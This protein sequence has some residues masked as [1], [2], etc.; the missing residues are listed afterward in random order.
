MTTTFGGQSTNPFQP[1]YTYPQ[2]QPAQPVSET[3]GT[4]YQPGSSENPYSPNYNPPSPFQPSQPAPPVSETKGTQYQPGSSEN[5]YQPNYQPNPYQPTAP[6]APSQPATPSQPSA[7]SPPNMVYVSTTPGTEGRLVPDPTGKTMADVFGAK[8]NIIDY[9]KGIL[10]GG[11]IGPSYMSDTSGLPVGGQST[12]PM[13]ATNVNVSTTPQAALGFPNQPI[14]FTYD[15]V[16][17]QTVEEKAVSKLYKPP[18]QESVLSVARGIVQGNPLTG[19]PL[20]AYGIASSISQFGG[21]KTIVNMGEGLKALPGEIGKDPLYGVGLVA[22]ALL[23]S[24]I[25]AIPTESIEPL[26]FVKSNTLVNAVSKDFSKFDYTGTRTAADMVSGFKGVSQPLRQ[27][28]N[29]VFTPSGEPVVS[30]L[31]TSIGVVKVGGK[32]APAVILSTTISTGMETVR[33][34][35]LSDVF[36][37]QRNIFGKVK[38][39][40]SFGLGLSESVPRG[41][42]SLVSETD[43]TITQVSQHET[44]GLAIS[45]EGF[46][47]VQD[48]A[49]VYATTPKLEM[50][51]GGKA[52][53]FT[54]PKPPIN[55]FSSGEGGTVP[56]G[57]FAGYPMTSNAPLMVKDTWSTL[58]GPFGKPSGT[59]TSE[60]LGNTLDNLK[61]TETNLGIDI[62]IGTLTSPRTGQTQVTGQGTSSGISMITGLGTVQ[63]TS[64]AQTQASEQLTVQL[65]TQTTAQQII[66]I[67][68]APFTPF[69]D[70]RF[71]ARSSGFKLDMVFGKKKKKTSKGMFGILPTSDLFD[72]ESTFVKYG[73]VSFPKGKKTEKAF[74]RQMEEYGVFARFPTFQQL[75]GGKFK[76]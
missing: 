18:G 75:K 24:G 14:N 56:A 68:L 55:T 76:L 52:T 19:V 15:L 74:G 49:T 42:V 46:K 58:T 16:P 1:N 33:D 64:Q 67:R 53:A 69:L 50:G 17:A 45:K 73:K 51:G 35:S 29:A 22:G 62:G 61:S 63:A 71:P 3:K 65:T 70:F 4:P 54:P 27:G 30:S 41:E 59:S 6:T 38:I 2:S 5:P 44:T 48:T 25:K 11:N 34:I 12:I 8:A 43:Q 9:A 66:P 40:E 32:P 26:A 10:T 39:K 60:K 28:G 31:D 7:P 37:A 57:M 47:G 21:A 72:I 23:P 36:V 13:Q 20:S